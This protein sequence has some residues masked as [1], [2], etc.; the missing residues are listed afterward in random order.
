MIGTLLSAKLS[1]AGHDVSV[2]ARGERLAAVEKHGLRIRG[3]GRVLDIAHVPALESTDARFDWVLATIRGDQV[4][5]SLSTLAA[6][7]SPNVMVW[8]GEPRGLVRRVDAR[9]R[10]GAGCA[11]VSPARAGPSPTTASSTIGSRPG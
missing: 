7:D 2:L 3:P 11:S 9:N 1:L 5:A 6:I 4:E 10:R 8:H